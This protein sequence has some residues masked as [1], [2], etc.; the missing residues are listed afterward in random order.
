MEHKTISLADQI[1][2]HLETDILSGVYKRGDILTE[3][4][5]CETLGVS[6]TPIREA[7]R[8]LA[9][10]HIIEETGKGSVVLGITKDDLVD[11]YTIRSRIEGLAASLAAKNITDEL[12]E[13]LTEAVDM[14][15]FFQTK[16]D[17]LKIRQYDSR[18]HE[19]IY[20]A[21]A[22]TVLY[23]TL[24]P[25]HKKVQKFRKASIESSGRAAASIAE[26]KGIL[27]AILTHDSKKAEELINKHIDNAFKSIM[28]SQ[29]I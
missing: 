3:L 6:R 11:I 18:F 2:E 17:S 23:D 24:M 26:H 27:E 28:E 4:K 25:L 7:L 5:L 22:S 8:R 29:S 12:K 15:E 9:T 19:L 16:N 13:Q 20:R 10:E 14:Q 21:S 1:F